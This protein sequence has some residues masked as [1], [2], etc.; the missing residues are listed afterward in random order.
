MTDDKL[1]VDNTP[2]F[3]LMVT[4]NQLILNMDTVKFCQLLKLIKKPS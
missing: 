1:M 2:V 3:D 4:Y